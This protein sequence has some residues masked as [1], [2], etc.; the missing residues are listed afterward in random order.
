MVVP[1][2]IS[3]GK[4]EQRSKST[5]SSWLVERPEPVEVPLP[6]TAERFL[7]VPTDISGD[8]NTSPTEGQG[9]CSHYVKRGLQT[10][11]PEERLPVTSPVLYLHE[12]LFK[13]KNDSG[14][15]CQ[16][17]EKGN[18]PRKGK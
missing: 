16:V 13:I 8:P 7:T 5:T 18:Q 11:V 3:P 9:I 1:W 6:S 10:L 2:L 12:R 14:S 4:G 17:P 15:L